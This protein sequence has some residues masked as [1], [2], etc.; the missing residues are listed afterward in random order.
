[1]TDNQGYERR[2]ARL[3]KARR[4]D[5][6]NKRAAVLAALAELQREDRRVTRTA[7]IARAGVHRNFLQRHKDLAALIDSAADGQRTGPGSPLADRLTHESL[8]TEL[9]TAKHR[10]QELNGRVQALERRLGA[11]GATLGQP[12][13]EN[14]PVVV[15][16]RARLARREVELSEKKR[17]I[18]ALLD[19]VEILRETNRSLVREYGLTTNS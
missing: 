9:A 17:T 4:G 1:V 18:E 15:D 5:S 6:A 16:L 19:D 12:V 8:R 2:I 14:H 13:I 10:N 7:V 3:S 11:H